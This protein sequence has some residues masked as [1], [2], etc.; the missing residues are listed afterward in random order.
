MKLLNSNSQWEHQIVP[1]QQTFRPNLQLSPNQLPRA[2]VV[3]PTSSKLHPAVP[4]STQRVL[5][6][7]RECSLNSRLHCSCITAGRLIRTGL[8]LCLENSNWIQKQIRF[9]EIHFPILAAETLRL[10]RFKVAAAAAAHYFEMSDSK[11]EGK[12]LPLAWLWLISLGEKICIICWFHSRLI[13]PLIVQDNNTTPWCWRKK[14][15]RGSNPSKWR[16]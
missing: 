13:C 15:S 14:T 6:K 12:Y 9:C 2:D 10:L 5:P 4:R 7:L 1:Q 3:V 16:L 8:L 11:T